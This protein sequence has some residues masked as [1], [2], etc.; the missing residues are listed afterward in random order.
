MLRNSLMA[1]E[2]VG[3][4]GKDI[5]EL[6]VLFVNRE[7]ISSNAKQLV[8][9]WNVTTSILNIVYNSFAAGE[10][11]MLGSLSELAGCMGVS[12]IKD[13]ISTFHRSH[14]FF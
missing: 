4:Y 8:E 2:T 6:I 13:Q 11:E 12:M 1:F 14:I 5:G 10:A 7:H 3:R 9:M